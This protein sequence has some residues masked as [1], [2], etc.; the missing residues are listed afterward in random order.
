MGP[1]VN[2]TNWTALSPE[3]LMC[4]AS[5]WASVWAADADS[6]T[7]P[8]WEVISPRRGLPA[9]ALK[10]ELDLRTLIIR[11]SCQASRGDLAP[12]PFPR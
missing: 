11:A 2:G 1:E 6:G 12:R 4:S 7:R 3:T 9:H 5:H 8:A 10:G